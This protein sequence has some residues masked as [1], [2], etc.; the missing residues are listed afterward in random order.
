MSVKP[1]DNE[2]EL[3]MKIAE[4]D[5]RSFTVLFNYY[6]QFVYGFGKRLTRSEEMALNIT[7][8]V[9]MKIW[10]RRVGLREVENF[11]A[12]LN[13]LVR[14][15]SFNM[16]RDLSAQAKQTV[17][18]SEADAYVQEDTLQQLD[19]DETLKLVNEAVEGLAPQQKLA[20]QLCH[21]QGLKYEQAAEEMGISAQT[22][23]VHMKLALK[24]IREHLKNNAVAYPLLIMALFK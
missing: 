13:R 22:V 17:D 9:F 2:K 7:Q 19:Y 12:Y 20:Y 21:R 10:E 8:D 4:G 1:L 16:L 3:L 23:H 6:Q 5:Q 14:N 24:K 18:L 11:P 15:R